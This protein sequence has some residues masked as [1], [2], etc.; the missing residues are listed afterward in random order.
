MPRKRVSIARLLAACIAALTLIA[1][2]PQAALAEEE[3]LWT[4]WAEEVTDR[5]TL[6]IPFAIL[7]SLPAMLM[8]TPFYWGILALDAM[9]DDGDE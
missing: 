9:D 8:T 5:D 6:E 7:F 1:A 3:K 4:R 2:L